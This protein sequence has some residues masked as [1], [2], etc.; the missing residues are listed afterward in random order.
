MNFGSIFNLL[1]LVLPVVVPKSAPI[2]KEVDEI[3]KVDVND[4]VSIDPLQAA[5]HA[6]ELASNLIKK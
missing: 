2:V 3:V 1:K 6:E 5:L 4:K